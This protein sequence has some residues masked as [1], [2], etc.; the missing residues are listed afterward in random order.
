MVK[1]YIVV[2]YN[3]EDGQWENSKVMDDKESCTL[4]CN[5]LG[6]DVYDLDSVRIIELELPEVKPVV[7]EY[8]VISIKVA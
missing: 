7:R 8:P 3:I 4:R 2:G 5:D 1:K 6:P